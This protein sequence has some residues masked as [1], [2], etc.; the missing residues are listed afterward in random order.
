MR[1]TLGKFGKFKKMPPN[2]KKKKKRYDQGKGTD[3]GKDTRDEIADKIEEL[4]IEKAN[5]KS[6]FIRRKDQLAD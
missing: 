2:S 3:D 6:L 1:F 5:S 4:K